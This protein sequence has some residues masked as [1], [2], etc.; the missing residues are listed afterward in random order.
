MKSMFALMASAVVAAAALPVAAAAQT[1]VTIAET[2]PVVTLNVTDDPSSSALPRTV[3]G[4]G[5]AISIKD[6]LYSPNPITVKARV[7]GRLRWPSGLP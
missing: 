6:F 1:S 3:G 2:A 5:T 4:T 7:S